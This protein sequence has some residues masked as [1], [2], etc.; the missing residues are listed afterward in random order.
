MPI[1]GRMEYGVMKKGAVSDGIEARAVRLASESEARPAFPS[2]A[3]LA[4]DEK[5]RVCSS[6]NA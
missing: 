2:A 1:H 6:V 5:T 4:V 3:F